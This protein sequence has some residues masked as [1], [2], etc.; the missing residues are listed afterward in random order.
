MTVIPEKCGYPRFERYDEFLEIV[1]SG[2]HP[3]DIEWLPISLDRSYEILRE[4][5][6]SLPKYKRVKPEHATRLVEEMKKYRTL[7]DFDWWPYS[8][9]QAFKV[10]R[11]AGVNRNSPRAY[12]NKEISDDIFLNILRDF[13]NKIPYEEMMLKYKMTRQQ[14]YTASAKGKKIWIKKINAKY[15]ILGMIL[16]S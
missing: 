7:Q 11:E 15:Y 1:R 4:E 9:G 12:K 3:K 5:G 16:K 2:V 13:E 6:I 14:L 10:L 8:R